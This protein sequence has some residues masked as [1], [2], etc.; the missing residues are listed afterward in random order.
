MNEDSRRVSHTQAVLLELQ[1]I[2]DSLNRADTSGLSFVITGDAGYVKSYS[3]AAR[4]I[5]EH[6][7]SLRK[8]TVDDAAQQR[9]IDNLEP[10][11]NS[12][13]RAIQVE[14]NSR[15]AERLPAKI[16][17]LQTLMRTSLGET[18]IVLEEIENAEIELL[19]QRNQA[20]QQANHRANVFFLL[21]G[22]VLGPVLI[23]AFALALRVDIT[24]RKR[25]EAEILALNA[26][27]EQRVL[28]RTAE[29]QAANAELE[30]ARER[31]VEIAS[32]IQQALLVEQ[33]PG[34]VPGLCVAAL[35]LPSQ[36]IDGDFYTFF[37]HQDESLDVI[38]GDVM[39]K[40][41]PPRSWAPPPRANYL[42]LLAI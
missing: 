17:P 35:T 29:L 31:E 26:R 38:V 33:P 2:R 30:H 8:L 27:L 10:L 25:A 9:R 32:R 40:G 7:Q 14:I 4:N 42:R 12:V 13:I 18:R 6:L 1:G 11:V 21:F 16:S 22:S 15:G 24:K 39:G 41:F 20:T 37:K 3:R 5:G 28:E 23:G 19:R 34:D 36:R